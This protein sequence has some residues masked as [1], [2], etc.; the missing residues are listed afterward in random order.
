MLVLHFFSITNLDSVK[1][2]RELSKLKEELDSQGATILAIATPIDDWEEV[3]KLAAAEG[4]GITIARDEPIRAGGKGKTAGA[5][6]TA[7]HTPTLLIDQKGV[8]R[9]AGLRPVRVSEAARHVA[10]HAEPT[11]M[12]ATDK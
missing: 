5:F 9:A 3:K 2:L 12:V 6:G 7:R 11:L 4:W 8:I 1:R 10:K